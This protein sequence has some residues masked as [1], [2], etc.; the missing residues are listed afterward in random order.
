MKKVLVHVPFSGYI[1]GYN[2]YEVECT[3][4]EEIPDLKYNDM[5]Y[6]ESEIIRDDTSCDWC[7]ADLIKEIIL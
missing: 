4:D 2:V 3:G 6:K 1:R 5:V 7:D